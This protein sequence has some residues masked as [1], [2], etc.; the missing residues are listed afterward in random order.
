G[1]RQLSAGDV[2][3]IRADAEEDE[4]SGQHNRGVADD[5]C[6]VAADFVHEGKRGQHGY[7]GDKS[8]DHSEDQHGP[9]HFNA[10]LSNLCAARDGLCGV[11]AGFVVI[12]S[13][14]FAWKVR[15]TYFRGMVHGMRRASLP[16]WT[17]CVRRL[18]PSLSKS[19]LEWVLP[20]FS[21][22]KS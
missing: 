21:L 6:L 16:S 5:Q 22:T 15:K 19:R 2:V 8:G 11:S 1:E 14:D 18:A 7:G 12:P 17:A 9:F 13:G 20:V 3:A 4:Q 10:S